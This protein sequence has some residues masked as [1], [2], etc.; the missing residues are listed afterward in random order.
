MFLASQGEK[1][2]QVAAAIGNRQATEILFPLTSKVETISNWTIDGILEYMQSE[3]NKEQVLIKE[4]CYSTLS[5]VHL[6]TFS[7]LLLLFFPFFFKWM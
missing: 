7:L 3:H 4:K 5:S 1:P 2:I 6:L